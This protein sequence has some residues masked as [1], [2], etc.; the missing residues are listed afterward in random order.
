[1][2]HNTSTIL[3]CIGGVGVVITSVLAVKATPK[4]LKVI[5]KAREE[6]GEEL[7]KS[8]I[9]KVAAPIYIPAIVAGVA[10]ITCIFGANALNKRQQASLMSA[11][12]LLDS[13]Y[14]AYKNK[15]RTLYGEDADARIREEIAKDH[16]REI[17][18]ESGDDKQLFYDQCSERYFESTMERVIA[19]EYAVNREIS[20]WGDANLNVFY[21][22]LDISPVDYGKYVGWS[23]GWL[24]FYHEK[25]E[26]DDGLEVYIIR[27]SIDP[28][29]DYE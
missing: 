7:T 14:K 17:K 25:V 1:M 13:S 20:L 8:D 11:Y 28:T 22:A 4:A 15:V 29:Y 3:T 10:T 23:A 5:E 24:D 6:K 18:F 26:F 12:T 21:D 9:V 2:N 16:Y 19:A 27:M